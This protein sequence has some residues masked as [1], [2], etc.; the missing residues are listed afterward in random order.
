VAIAADT[1]FGHYLV[2]APLGAGGMGEVW[3]ARDMRL[4]RAVALKLLPAWFAKDVDLPILREA[5]KE[6]SFLSSEAIL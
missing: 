2:L 4:N 6:K 3:R 5:G 1:R